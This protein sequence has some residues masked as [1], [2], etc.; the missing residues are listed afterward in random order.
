[1]ADMHPTPPGFPNFFI[2]GAPK[3]GTTAL[4]EYLRRHPNIGFS[5]Q[6]EPHYFNDDFSSR[7]IYSL[8][9]YMKCF[10]SN[11]ADKVA[12]GEAS[13][14]YLSSRSAVRNI[15]QHMPDAKFIV[16]LRDPV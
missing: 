16:M 7:H 4:S 5:E 3:C 9:E 13:V 2:I 8:D 11:S 1:M 6:K 14:F 10:A 12:I 15:L